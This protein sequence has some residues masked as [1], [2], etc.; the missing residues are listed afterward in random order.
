M[1]RWNEAKRRITL[2]HRGLDF[3]DAE[4]VFAGTHFTRRDDRRDY[5]EPRFISAGYIGQRFVVVG[6]TPRDGGRRIISMRLG[7][8]REAAWYQTCLD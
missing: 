7:H 2:L 6:W 4:Q 3:A 5:G 8:E 1:D